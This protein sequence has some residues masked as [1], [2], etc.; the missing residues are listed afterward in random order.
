MSPFVWFGK[1]KRGKK[2]KHQ[3]QQPSRKNNKK[4]SLPRIP[5]PGNF[6]KDPFSKQKPFPQRTL[7]S[8]ARDVFKPHRYVEGHGKKIE[9]ERKKEI[10]FLKRVEN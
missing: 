2:N 9:E 4:Q 1:Q 7:K 10:Y 6:P 8:N 5:P 3:K